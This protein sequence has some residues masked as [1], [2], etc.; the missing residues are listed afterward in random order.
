MT[1]LLLAA[2]SFVLG[3][4]ECDP[5]DAS[6]CSQQLVQGQK[7]PYTGELLTRPLAFDTSWKAFSCEQYTAIEVRY[8]KKEARLDLKLEKDFRQNDKKAHDESMEAMKSDRDQW[9]ERAHIPFYE[10][11][12]F[13]TIATAVVVAAV[14][15]GAD[16]IDK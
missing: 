12:W 11:P 13:V 16:Q 8:A 4:P 1:L 2:L 6:K 7:A 9:K 5:D 3:A 10:K 14:F 15:V